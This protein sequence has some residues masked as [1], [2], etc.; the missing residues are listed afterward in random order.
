MALIFLGKSGRTFREHGGTYNP[1][2]F[3]LNQRT[4]HILCKKLR[5]RAL[6]MPSYREVKK[7]LARRGPP[8]GIPSPRSPPQTPHRGR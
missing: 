1:A 3:T 6:E 8:R 4:D 2:L 7:H 5:G